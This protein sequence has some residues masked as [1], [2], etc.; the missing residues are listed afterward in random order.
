MIPHQ[1]EVSNLLMLISLATG[2]APESVGARIGEGGSGMLKSVVT[3]TLNEYLRPLRKRRQE[4]EK[5]ED[6]IREVLSAGI[7]GASRLQ[8]K[9]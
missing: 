4:L 5:N 8:S 2:E 3:E 1:P 6:Y 9:H 7:S